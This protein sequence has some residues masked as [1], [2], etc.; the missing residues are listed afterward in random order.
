MRRLF[1][2]WLVL[3][4]PIAASAQEGEDRGFIVGLLESSLGG[5]GRTVR[6]DGFAGALSSRATI[7]RITIADSEGIWLT[8]EDIAMQW[9]RAALFRATIDIQE[10][11]AARIDLPR[12]PVAQGTDL[13]APEATPFALPDLPAAIRIAQLDLGAVSLGAPLLGEAAVL[14]VSGAA[15]LADGAG[16]T[17]INATRTDGARAS[18]DVTAAYANDTRDLTLDLGLSEA[19]NG[20]I[21]GLLNLPDRPSVDL[22][23]NGSGALSDFN[24]TLDLRTDDT[25]RLAGTLAL[26]NQADG[27]MAFDAALDGDIS[28]LVL[29]EYR[30]FFGTDVGLAAQGST[31]ANGALT[32]ESFAL[33][34]R[35][36]ALAGQASL[37]SDGWPTLLDIEGALRD[38]DGTPVTLP[39]T[40]GTTIAEAALD[41]AFDAARSDALQAR[42]TATDL[43]QNDDAV[44]EVALTFDG[45]LS[46][47][48]DAIGALEGRLDLRANGI[49]LSDTGLARAVGDTVSGGLNIAYADDA[50]LR[51]AN[52]ALTGAAWALGGTVEVSGFDDGFETSFDTNLSAQDLSAFADLAGVALS[53]AGDLSASGTAALGGFFDVTV[54]GQTRDLAVGI[55][56]ADPVLAGQTD[57]VLAARRDTTGTVL[58][59]LTLENEALDLTAS[60]DL[61][62]GASVARFNASLADAGLVTEAVAGP[63]TMDG[64]ATQTGEVWDISGALTGPL[65]TTATATARVAGDQTDISLDARVA[66]LQALVPQINAPV[67]LT[68]TAAQRDGAW[69]FD[70][71]I[72]GPAEAR[73]A[74]TGLFD[75]T[76][77]SAR[78]DVSAPNLS[79]FAPGVPGG[80]ALNGDVRQTAE[81]WAFDTALSGP[82][83]SS[84]TLSGTFED[85]L[86][87]DFDLS[88]PNVA[89]V[90][91]GVRGPLN[92]DGTLTQTATG[93][94]VVTDVAGPY[95]STGRV[96]ASLTDGV[97]AA[98]YALSLPNVAPLVPGLSGGASV[99][100]TLQQVGDAFD[101]DTQIA[102]PSGT[103]ATAT[104]RVQ[105]DG[106]LNLSTQ[107]QLQL[108][109]IN[110]FIT[111]RSILGTARFDLAMNGPPALGSVSGQITTQGARVAT[112]NLPVTISD[113]SGVVQLSGGQAALD[114]NAAIAE[115]G[116]VAISGPITLNGG[117]S[118]QLAV[119]LNAVLLKDP[120]LY[121]T[122][123]DGRVDLRGPLTGGAAISGALNLGETNVQVPST[124]IASFG[125]IPDITHIGATR[126]VMRT[127]A[128]AG[129][130]REESAGGTGAAYPLDLTINAPNRI[131]IRGRGLDAEL[132]GRL[133]LSGTTA[134]IISTGQFDLIRGR[135]S[136]LAQRFT[137]DEGRVTLQG[138]FEPIL[139]FVVETDTSTG[140][141][142]IIVDG[143]ADDPDVRFEATPEAPED[144][145][146][147]Q[148]I[149]GRDI[150]QL[151][152]FQALQLASAVASLAGAG[153]EGV[154]SQLRGSFGLDDLDVAS[155]EEGNT[156]VR[157]GRYLSENVYTDVT[158]GGADG[159]EV[160]LNIDLTP[161]I[162]ARGSVGGDG[163]TGIGIF[164]E[165]DY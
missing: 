149:F 35:S 154:V 159:P 163:N 44:N 16:S 130:I 25:P 109:L 84:G 87:T 101:I 11:R 95:N 26:Q 34:A 107:G 70:T 57:V 111:P 41:I 40:G 132:G 30:D 99:N 80:A 112:P 60:A 89:A 152:A 46:R 75:G 138:R 71:T 37:N 18:F 126:P 23:V 12:L 153:G 165:R 122:T 58:D 162:T 98:R 157:A 142:R 97:A 160:S 127:Q 76:R 3:L 51:L 100:G 151:S 31:D 8:L 145:V 59:R 134:D 82:Y 117:Y 83:D 7:E 21:S 143:P 148:I 15:E 131:F 141:A 67:R 54:T 65:E 27:P 110:P 146:L 121:S 6:I 4:W 119:A 64:T 47:D 94:D 123:V 125:A 74:V 72:D 124:G 22:T 42:I 19:E 28:A 33:T 129:L 14:S 17:T 86:V 49:A 128:R 161:N 93:W 85:T 5:E 43:D 53:G 106:T 32:L 2:I 1:C 116:S 69:Q 114:F 139:L 147:A 104:G 62:T 120:T 90:A 77:L 155:D 45:T 150:S 91:P 113:L 92:L 48:V 50:P 20:L 105:T 61:R 38:P 140:T 79:A 133:R 55:P 136:I 115:G 156:A 9:N 29:Q 36:V 39:G 81:G 135:L 118:A 63:I 164:I 13:P 96:S 68:A 102:G 88:V 108:G 73:A 56:Q 10:L 52:L 103:T 24:A 66:D 137:L 78:Y 144:Q 158:V